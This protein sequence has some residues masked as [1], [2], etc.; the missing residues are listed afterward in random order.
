MV[1]RKNI[2]VWSISVKTGRIYIAGVNFQVNQKV[3]KSFSHRMT[4]IDYKGRYIH[5]LL[6]NLIMWSFKNAQLDFQQ[7]CTIPLLWYLKIKWLLCKHNVV[8]SL[9]FTHFKYP[10][11]LFLSFVFD[12]FDIFFA[13][14]SESCF[15]L[16]QFTVLFGEQTFQGY[17][18]FVKCLCVF[19]VRRVLFSLPFLL[20]LGY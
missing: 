7:W 4:R 5:R 16:L 19:Y 17:T 1:Y 6:W 14:F 9:K 15:V 18:N 2:T 12:F 11:V 3:E 10:I 8:N 20:T 13:L